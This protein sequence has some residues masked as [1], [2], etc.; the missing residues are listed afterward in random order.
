MTLG[1]C[2]VADDGNYHYCIS[3]VSPETADVGEEFARICAS[4]DLSGE[5]KAEK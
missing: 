5:E 2:M 3:M 4:L 1:R